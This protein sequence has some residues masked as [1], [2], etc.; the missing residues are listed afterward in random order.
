MKTVTEVLNECEVPT[1]TTRSPSGWQDRHTKA[2]REPKGFERAIVLMVTGVAVYIDQHAKRYE[3]PIAHD[4]VLGPSVLDTLRAVRSLLNGETG[5]LD[6]ST[7]DRCILDLHA[8]AGF[9]G[10]L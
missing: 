1:E 9:E 4:Y 10:E 6:C 7:L 3:S 2:W 8:V 5:R